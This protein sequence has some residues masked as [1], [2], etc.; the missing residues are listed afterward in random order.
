LAAYQMAKRAG[1]IRL[2]LERSRGPNHPR[3]VHF[4]GGGF[5]ANLGRAISVCG[6][7]QPGRPF[8]ADHEP[9]HPSPTSPTGSSSPASFYKPT[10]DE[11]DGARRPWF[12]CSRRTAPGHSGP[13]S[14]RGRRGW[15]TVRSCHPMAAP[16]GNLYVRRAFI[17]HGG[18]VAI[19]AA[20]AGSPPWAAAPPLGIY[21]T[22][23]K[24]HS[25]N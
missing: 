4:Q 6:C 17:W 21:L 5:Y 2:R 18:Y 25:T 24:C 3:S 1:D 9:V 23:T 12:C 14:P 13:G 15:R 11:H 20:F 8:H 19:T 7:S 16:A 22:L 10:A